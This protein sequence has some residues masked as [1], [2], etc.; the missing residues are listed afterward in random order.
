MATIIKC[1]LAE[2]IHNKA[3]RC[4]CTALGIKAKVTSDDP[5]RPGVVS[6]MAVCD[7]YFRTPIILAK[8]AGVVDTDVKS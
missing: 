3:D 8:F 6:V 4:Q 2:C 5:D 1:G 7:S